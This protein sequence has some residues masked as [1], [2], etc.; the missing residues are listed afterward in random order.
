MAVDKLVVKDDAFA[1]QG[2]QDEF[3]DGQ[4]V[5]FGEGRGAEPVLVGRQD[6]FVPQAGQGLEAADGARDEAEFG[7]GIDLFVRGLADDR[8]VTVDEQGFLHG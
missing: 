6:Q 1:L 7:E 4:E 5:F 3:V 8:A 2:V